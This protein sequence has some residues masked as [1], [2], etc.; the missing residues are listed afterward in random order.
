MGATWISMQ[1]SQMRFLFFTSPNRRSIMPVPC[2]ILH[3]DADVLCV[4]VVRVRVLA[5][6][7]AHLHAYYLSIWYNNF[8]EGGWLLSIGKPLLRGSQSPIRHEAQAR[9][10]ADWPHAT[11]TKEHINPQ[12]REKR[13]FRDSNRWIVVEIRSPTNPNPLV[14]L[15]DLWSLGLKHNNNP[16]KSGCN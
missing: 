2:C 14:L 9:A 6:L 8:L 15:C 7:H 16:L 10:T 5:P 1:S 4:V 3:S 11:H 13:Y 12:P